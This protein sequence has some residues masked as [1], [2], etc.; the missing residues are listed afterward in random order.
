ML[1][2]LAIVERSVGQIVSSEEANKL[3]M[4]SDK[5]WKLRLGVVSTGG[6][7]TPR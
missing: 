3:A 2:K 5:N 6:C 7:L 1:I 4:I